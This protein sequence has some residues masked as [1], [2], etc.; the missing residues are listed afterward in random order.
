MSTIEIPN[1]YTYMC[2]T[3]QI[4]AYM[5]DVLCFKCF[6][7]CSQ[8]SSKMA[9]TS[10]SLASTW[11]IKSEIVGSNSNG[12]GSACSKDCK[13]SG[14]R[15]LAMRFLKVGLEMFTTLDSNNL[16]FF[17]FSKYKGQDRRYIPDNHLF[18]HTL[19]TSCRHRSWY[20]EEGVGQLSTSSS[21]SQIH[22]LLWKSRPVFPQRRMCGRISIIKQQH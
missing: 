18:Y 14:W 12:I 22:H 17:F 16:F 3:Q 20:Q 10:S 5:S 19:S 7:F 4:Q 11:L 9:S 8:T 2:S 13:T 21:F 1:L 15:Y 6:S